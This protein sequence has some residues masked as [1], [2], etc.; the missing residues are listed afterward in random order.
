M[1][2]QPKRTSTGKDSYRWAIG[3]MEVRPDLWNAVFFQSAVVSILLYWCTTWT[4]TKRMEKKF[5][6]NYTRMIRAIL[7]K[8]W[9]QHRT[10][11]HLYSH[12]PPIRETIKVRRSRH[13]GYCWRSRDELLSSPV[14][15]FTWTSKGRKTSS[16]LHTATLCQYGMWLWGPAGSDGR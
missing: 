2:H 12:L 13:A 4:L 14:D 8:Y 15:P 6:S 5:N 10:K 16:N 3:Y 7:N 11:Q 9:R 1:S